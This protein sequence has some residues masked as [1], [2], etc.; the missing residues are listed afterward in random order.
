[1]DAQQGYGNIFSTPQHMVFPK[2]NEKLKSQILS[3][4]DNTIKQISMSDSTSSALIHSNSD[5]KDHLYM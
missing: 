1:M 5:H 3:S 4:K 2:E